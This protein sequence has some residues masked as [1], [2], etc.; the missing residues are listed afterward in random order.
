MSEKRNICRYFI[1]GSLLVFF[2]PLILP[3][4]FLNR[5]DNRCGDYSGSEYE[6][7]FATVGCYVENAVCCQQ[8]C[9]DDAAPC[10]AGAGSIQFAVEMYISGYT[11]AVRGRFLL[12]SVAEVELKAGN[13][14]PFFREQDALCGNG[15]IDGEVALRFFR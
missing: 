3:A 13:N 5:N 14:F 7:V 15:G 9:L 2:L 10:A 4:E 6:H 12:R 1:W 11:D 8:G